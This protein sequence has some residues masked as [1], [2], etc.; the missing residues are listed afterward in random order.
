M[1]ASPLAV[2]KQRFGITEKDP[3]EARKKAKAELISA[4]K[5]FTS[6]GLWID[7]VND[8]KGLEHIS[9]AK[10]LRLLDTLEAVKSRFGSREK[11]IDAIVEGEGRSKDKFYKAHFADW[12]TP[13][14]WDHFKS[15]EKR[16]AN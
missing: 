8:D 4:L 10:M 9:N 11:L 13:R 16:T 14:L 5:K 1:K 12:P 15:V 2:A 3:T 7:R 6:D